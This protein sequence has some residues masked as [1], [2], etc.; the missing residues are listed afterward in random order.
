MESFVS[1]NASNSEAVQAT[2]TAEA[3]QATD[4]SAEYERYAPA[5]GL[6]EFKEDIDL[7][8]FM[9]KFDDGINT[10]NKNIDTLRIKQNEFN[11]SSNII[12]EK[13]DNNHKKNTFDR[14]SHLL[15]EKLQFYDYWIDMLYGTH[16]IMIVVLC[17]IVIIMLIYKLMNKT[18]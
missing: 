14:G 8:D 1:N 12:K 4:T 9:G 17:I 18:N 16:K 15:A 3:V 2:D 11:E 10:F 6:F 5:P 13:I 7:K